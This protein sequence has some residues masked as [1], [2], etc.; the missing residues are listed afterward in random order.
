M[1]ILYFQFFFINEK[2]LKQFLSIFLFFF[3]KNKGNNN[4][5]AKGTKREKRKEDNID[6][7]IKFLAKLLEIKGHLN[8]FFL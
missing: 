3:K 6:I 4:L 5:L 7:F 2:I 8:V 1:K